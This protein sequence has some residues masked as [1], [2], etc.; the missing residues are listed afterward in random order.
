[1]RDLAAGEAITVE[2]RDTKE[3]LM[4]SVGDHEFGAKLDVEGAEHL[5]LPGLLEH[6]RLT[7]VVFETSLVEDWEPVRRLL[8]SNGF[9]LFGLGRR[10]LRAKFIPL[11]HSQRP[12]DFK[13]VVAIHPDRITI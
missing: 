8:D 3:W 12:K 7:F 13:D 2:V 6:P 5:V 10:L 11:D 4:S 1:M 9:R